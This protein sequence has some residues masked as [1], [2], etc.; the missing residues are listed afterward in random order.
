MGQ[1]SRFPHN[2]PAYLV[3][4]VS[5]GVNCLTYNDVFFGIVTLFVT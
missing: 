2:N 4:R 5:T 1:L 3:K